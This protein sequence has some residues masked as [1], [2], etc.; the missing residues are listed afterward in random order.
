MQC[1]IALG[2]RQKK[3]DD[4]IHLSLGIEE[5]RNI[6]A[7]L[8]FWQIWYTLGTLF[9]GPLIRVVVFYP[10]IAHHQINPTSHHN[11]CTF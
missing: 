9:I 8:I 2:E 3:G 11:G 7:Y 6:Y 4:E 1:C 5:C 10:A